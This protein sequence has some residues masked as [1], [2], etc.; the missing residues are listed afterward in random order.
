MHF[1][2]SY[3]RNGLLPS[4]AFLV[5]YFQTHVD[6]EWILEVYILIMHQNFFVQIFLGKIPSKVK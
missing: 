1:V 3:V 2:F 5:F 4:D 6:L